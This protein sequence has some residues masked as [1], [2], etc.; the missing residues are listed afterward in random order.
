MPKSK[1]EQQH[2]EDTFHKSRPANIRKMMSVFTIR[3][4]GL[5]I[6]LYINKHLTIQN[7]LCIWFHRIGITSLVTT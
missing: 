7:V 5:N 4:G 3:E 1:R 6:A 2:L